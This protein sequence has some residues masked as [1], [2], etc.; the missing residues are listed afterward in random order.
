MPIPD[1][2]WVVLLSMFPI[3]ELRGGIPLAIIKYDYTCL[4]AYLICFLA[5]IAIVPPILLLLNWAENWLKKYSWGERFFNWLWGRIRKGNREE[6]LKKYGTIALIPLVAIPLPVTGAWTG[7]LLAYI[8]NLDKLK[9]FL[10]ISLGVAIAGVIMCAA[11]AGIK[12]LEF[13]LP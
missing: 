6:K 4:Q 3:S 8:L 13:L 1:W 7:S 10:F 11:A 2:V 12:S 9:A 5:N